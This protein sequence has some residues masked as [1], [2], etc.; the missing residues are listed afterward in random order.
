MR[1]VRQRWDA[2]Q[3]ARVVSEPRE[4]RP[5]KSARQREHEGVQ[6]G[7]IGVILMLFA[8]YGLILGG[9]AMVVGLVMWGAGMA[10]SD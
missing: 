10:R 3:A 9:I 5:R 6:W 8:P 4:P 7:I 1:I 2:R